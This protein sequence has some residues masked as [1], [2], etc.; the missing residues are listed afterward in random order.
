M[1]YKSLDVANAFVSAGV[2][3]LTPMKLQKLI[4]FA[5]G[6]H[7]ALTGKPL[8]DEP[9]EAWKYGPVL[10]TVYFEFNHYGANIVAQESPR[11]TQKL[12]REIVPL[13]DKIL[14]RYGHYS[15]GTLSALTHVKDS[16]WSIVYAKLDGSIIDDRIILA[17]FKAVMNGR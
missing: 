2:P 14:R 7:L 16:P 11:G 5:H 15:A 6:W 4:Y 3:G 10:R 13:I 17:D 12:P 9:F 1:A 8:V